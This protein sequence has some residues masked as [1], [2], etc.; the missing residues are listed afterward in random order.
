V[1]EKTGT[2]RIPIERA[3]ELIVQRGIPVRP[4][5]AA[6]ESPAAKTEVRGHPINGLGKN[7]LGKG[8]ASSRALQVPQNAG[9]SP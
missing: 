8:T 6:R 2:V 5:S 9:F 4:P 3:M 1:D 7:G